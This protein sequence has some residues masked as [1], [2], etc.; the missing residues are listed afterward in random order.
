MGFDPRTPL[1]QDDDDDNET[2]NP[3]KE[4][5]SSRKLLPVVNLNPQKPP[6][7]IVTQGKYSSRLKALDLTT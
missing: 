7:V 5:H 6:P 3:A 2:E 1:L 4:T